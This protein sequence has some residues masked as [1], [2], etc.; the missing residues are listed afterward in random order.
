MSQ[1]STLS[2]SSSAVLADFRK[3]LLGVPPAVVHGVMAAAMLCALA[4]GAIGAMQPAPA[5]VV[6]PASSPDVPGPALRVRCA[7]CGFVESIRHVQA[8][9]LV[10]AAYELTV[11]MRD[12]SLRTSSD[13]S[14]GKWL[15]GDRIMLVGG[16]RAADRAP[17]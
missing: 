10:P 2:F 11:R 7:A 14:A 6:A 16:Q 5:T 4:P 3:A 9:G 13:A 8:A 12:G 15:V 17:S 1:A